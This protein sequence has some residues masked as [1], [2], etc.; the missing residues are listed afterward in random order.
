MK[1]Q[2]DLNNLLSGDFEHLKS[3]VR[4]RIGFY[5]RGGFLAFIDSLQ[6]H[7]HLHRFMSPDDLIK[8][9]SI[10]EGIEINTSTYRSM[11]ELLT[12]QRYRLLE[13][14]VPNAPTASVRLKCHYGDN[15]SSLLRR[16]HCSLLSQLELSLV[17][18]DRQLPVSKLHYE[19]NMLDESQAFRDLENTSKAPHLPDK[20]TAV[21]DFFRRGVTLYGTIIYPSSSDINHDPAI[22]DAIEGFGQSSIGSEG[23]PAN[24]IYQFGGQFLEAIMLNE[25]SHTTEFKSKQ[26][27]IQPGIVKGHINWTKEKGTI[28][29]V[30]TLDVYTI[31]QC[32][33]RSKYAMQKYYAIGSDG[34]SL[35]E[36]SD[37]ELELVN[38]RC[39]DERL[40]VTE[41]QIVPI[42]TLSAKLAIPV[43][44]STGRHYLKVTDFT[45]CFNTDELHST[46]EYDL[47]QAFENRGAYC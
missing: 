11:H 28:V 25:F 1:N 37:K 22:I 45:V 35:L 12:N 6:T 8:A 29:A 33:L 39:R 14:I 46:R 36:V 32:D 15:F 27:G 19:Q 41:N 5:D 2:N 13:D 40:G 18:I 10:I 4:S 7:L 23:T 43:D 31:N 44:I 42:C 16:L 38:K 21:K 3:Q 20:S 9:L 34:I 47:N 24:K 30:V 26:R 17:H